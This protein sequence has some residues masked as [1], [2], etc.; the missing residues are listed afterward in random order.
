MH[1]DSTNLP[2]RLDTTMSRD[3]RNLDA[4]LDRNPGI[5][6]GCRDVDFIPHAMRPQFSRDIANADEAD[7]V[8]RRED[9]EP[10]RWD[11]QS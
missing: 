9:E 1:S 6:P 7:P 11:G 3:T 5:P 10:E 2:Q 8:E 4:A